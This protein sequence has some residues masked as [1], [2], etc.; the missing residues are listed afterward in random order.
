MRKLLF[1]LA[2]IT[3]AAPAMAALKVGDKAPDFTTVGAV[4]GKDFKIH[5]AE[6]E[7]KGPV[8]LYF[9]PKAFTSGC[10]AEAHAFSESIGE[11]KKAG[12]QVIG[13]SGDDLVTLHSFST[14]E[15]RS[16]FPVGTA[17]SAI[18]K[19]YDVAWSRQAERK[20]DS[21][22]SVTVGGLTPY[23]PV[24]VGIDSTSLDD[25]MLTPKTPLQVV[26]P[27]PGVAADVQIALVGGGDI[28]GALIKSGELGF[29]GVD[30]ELVD[31]SGKVAGSAR[32]D[33]DGFFLF[34]RV[35][36][37]SYSLRVSASSAAA[38]KIAAELGLKVHIDAK[39]TVV[40]LG[41]I[42]PH[43]SVHLASTELP[44]ANPPSP[45]PGS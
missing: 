40:R 15:C 27:R 41:S 43:P 3:V 42:Q 4:G 18:Q 12:A 44:G 23:M 17:T 22:G 45:H 7:K 13:M 8:V 37:G 32:T 20:T 9:F 38:A 35:A 34:E 39:H 28:E 14:K 5:L 11:F 31:S 16:A 6:L 29:E 26:V 33:F 21:K 19:A 30:L 10:T 36:Y 2:A 24:P 25:P 1:A